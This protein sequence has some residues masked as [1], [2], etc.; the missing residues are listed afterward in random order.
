MSFIK[1]RDPQITKLNLVLTFNVSPKANS[2]ASTH[3]NYLIA[4]LKNDPDDSAGQTHN[5]TGESEPLNSPRLP[6]CLNFRGLAEGHHSLSERGIIAGKS[7]R[8]TP[9]FQSCEPDPARTGK[10]AETIGNTVTSDW[11][12]A[13]IPAYRSFLSDCQFL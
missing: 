6:V 12:G 5:Y 9:Y 4:L 7:A 13:A 3:T 1:E 11:P 8:S 10:R 2:N